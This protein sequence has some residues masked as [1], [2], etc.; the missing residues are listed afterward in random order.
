MTRLG[1]FCLTQCGSAGSGVAPFNESACKAMNSPRRM[2]SGFEASRCEGRMRR[3]EMGFMRVSAS[4]ETALERL[5]WKRRIHVWPGAGP[6]GQMMGTAVL[7]PDQGDSITEGDM[8]SSGGR[9]N[10]DG[11][12][13]V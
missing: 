6:N 7:K 2:P 4:Q 13:V 3:I 10:M 11:N 9:D 8:G 5:G 1:S 12:A